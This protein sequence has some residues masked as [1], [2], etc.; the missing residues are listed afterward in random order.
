M[1]K[2]KGG[3]SEKVIRI[4]DLAEELG[5]EPRILR[6]F[7]RKLGINA[8]ETGTKGFG[9]KR[10][11]EWK[12]GDKELKKIREAWKE[13]QEEE[14]KPKKKKED[15]KSAGKGKG[16]KQE[17]PQPEPEEDEEEELEE[18]DEEF[19]YEEEDDEEEEE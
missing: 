4:P 9:P 3:A 5:T 16:K 13:A 11:Y 10:K 6:M 14:P 17:E 12:E 1:A 8:P 19:E 18:E 2:K 7:I 15:N